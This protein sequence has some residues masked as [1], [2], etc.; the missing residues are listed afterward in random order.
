MRRI[1]TICSSRGAIAIYL[2][3]AAGCFYLVLKPF[4]WPTVIPPKLDAEGVPSISQSSASPDL[5]EPRPQR[6]LPQS[7]SPRPTPTVKI[8][9][10]KG[11]PV[12]MAIF[13]GKK[14]IVGMDVQKKGTPLRDDFQSQCGKTIWY[15]AKGWPTPGSASTQR[16]LI[17]GHMQCGDEVYSINN[18]KNARKGAILKVTFD[19]GCVVVAKAT[20]KATNIPKVD[21]NER[22]KLYNKELARIIRVSTCDDEAVK[23]RYGHST[24]N[25]YQ[26]FEVVSVTCPS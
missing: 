11:L 12:E 14:Q 26:M 3:I 1:R 7:T 18:L 8:T 10:P 5:H 20:I 23:D 25:Y 17:T 4:L 6:T 2:L 21:L 15:S 19:S 13:Q 22:D 9:D 16:S 24:K